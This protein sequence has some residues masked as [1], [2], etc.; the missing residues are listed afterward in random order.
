MSDLRLVLRNLFGSRSRFAL[1][2]TGI[3]LGITALVVMMSLGSGLRT[4]IDKQASDLGANLVVTPKGWCAYEQVKVLSGNQLPDAIPPDELAKIEAIEGIRTLPYLTVGSA[5]ENEPVPV[6]GIR[7]ADTLTEK[8]WTVATG[9]A[10]RDGANEILAGPDIAEAF[11]LKPGSPVTLRGTEFTVTGVLDATGTRDDG[12]LFIPIDVAQEVYETDGRVSFVAVK[13]EDISQ[14]DLFAQRI[15]DAANVAVVS[16]KQLLASVLSVVDSVGTT[17][18]VIAAVA[19]LTAAFGIVNTM[20][21]AT[22]ERRRDIGILKSVGSSN[23]RIFRLFLFEAAAYGLVGGLVGLVVGS[24]AS[25]VIT[26]YIAS[27]EF[28]AFIGG[29]SVQ[30]TPPFSEMGLILVGAVAVAAVAGVYPALRAARLTP[31]EAISYE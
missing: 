14:V 9:E 23:A 2:L 26:P 3:T 17:L 15:A 5:L 7:V 19:I 29:A 12:V 22:F 1:T 20:L 31:V 25:L 4:Q 16:D 21:M 27:N 6:T 10:A 28:T 13:V 30:A 8:G 11:A 24:V 18:R